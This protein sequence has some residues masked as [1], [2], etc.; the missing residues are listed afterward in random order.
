[1][2]LGNIEL[3]L[4]LNTSPATAALQQY[5]QKL[6]QGAQQAARSQKPVETAL[7]KLVESARKLGF[8]YDKTSKTF[9]DFK[10]N[11][12]SINTV[13]KRVDDLNASLAKTGAVAKGALGGIGAGFKQVLQG[14]PQGIG[15]AIGQQLLAPLTNFQQVVGGAVKGAVDGFVDIDEQLRQTLSISGESANRFGELAKA[16]NELAAQTK[17][18]AGELSE[19]S[20]QL[21]RAGFSVD[22]I[23]EA[24][25]GIAQG[26]AAAGESM[27]GMSDVVIAALGGFQISTSETTDVVDVLTAAA[28][29]SNTSVVELGEGLK[30]VGPIAKNLGL[31]F[32]DTAAVAAVLA[33]NGIKASQMG[34]AL[35]QGL[36]RLGTA[37]AGTEAAMGDLSRGTANQAEVLSRL[38]VELQTAEGTLVPF[39][40]L[41]KRLRDGFA[42][43]RQP[44]A[45]S[46]RKDP[47]RY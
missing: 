15:L 40:E 19:A 22:E 37:A 13:K 28:N 16:M 45:G 7:G 33:N 8:T 17:F 21:A 46:G 31:T 9:K 41:L 25:P 38:G 20:V 6:N 47:L 44:R 23:K 18:T 43:P 26:A 36:Q 12:T 30:Y 34:T 35:R 24:L 2:S 11:A 4:G 39:P 5:Y 3:Q 14:I 27:E 42:E 1:M 10:G 29:S 32:E